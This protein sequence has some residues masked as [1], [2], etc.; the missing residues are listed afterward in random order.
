[1]S[2]SAFRPRHL[3]T[4]PIAAVSFVATFLVVGR[5]VG[6]LSTPTLLP[7]RYTWLLNMLDD[8]SRW[9]TAL[10]ALS[11]DCLLAVAFV[12]QHSLMRTAPVRQLW[13]RLGLET[14]ERSLYNLAT[15][16]T[17]NVSGNFQRK[18]V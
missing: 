1:M 12:L 14:V 7:T 11:V 8:R 17:L 13:R 2:P 5:L 6:F 4:V 15:A 16:Y 3:C 9:E 18:P 10:P